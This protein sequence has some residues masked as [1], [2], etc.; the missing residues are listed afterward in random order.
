MNKKLLIALLTLTCGTTCAL[1]LSACNGNKHTHSFSED[2]K[3]D[4]NSHWHQA[5]CEHTDVKGS[6]APHVDEDNNGECDI[7]KYTPMDVSVSGTYYFC[8]NGSTDDQ[9]Y[10]TFKNGKWTDDEGLTGDYS[11][12]GNTVTLYL[13]VENEK[14][15]FASGTVDG[16]D[17]AL[18]LAGQV[19]YRKGEDVDPTKPKEKTLSYSLSDDRSYYIVKGIGGLTGDIE[20][21]DEYKRKPVKEIAENA[22]ANSTELTGLKIGSNVTTIGKKAFYNCANLTAA[23]IGDSVKAVPASAFENCRK[24]T[25]ITVG[26]AVSEFGEKAFYF[27][28]KLKDVYFNGTAS[29]WAQINFV[30]NPL[31]DKNIYIAGN[32]TATAE[33]QS[34]DLYV[35]GEILTDAE[36]TDAETISKSAFFGY[37]KLQSVTVGGSVG[38]IGETA[39]YGCSSLK[40]VSVTGD[41]KIIRKSAFRDCADLTS[42]TIGSSVK[43]IEET[44]FDSCEK[45]ETV[46]I[47]NGVTY[48]GYGAFMACGKLSS[49]TLGNSVVEICDSAFYSCNELT[50][51]TIPSSTIFIGKNAFTFTGLTSATF[52]STTGWIANKN[53]ALTGEQLSDTANAA[54]LLISSVLDKGY[55]E[56]EWEKPTLQYTLSGDK[57]Y[58]IVNNAGTACRSEIVIPETH[59][60]LPVRAISSYAFNGC[61]SL[62]SISLPGCIREIGDY[63]FDGCSSLE[64]IE[65]RGSLVSDY[66]EVFASSDGVLYNADF[67]EVICVPSAKT[68]LTLTAVTEIADEMFMYCSN[69]KKVTIGNGVTKIGEMA[70]SG[71]YNLA[72]ISI[73]DSVEYISDYAFNGCNKLRYNEQGGNL[74][75]GNETNPYLV[76]I[77]AAYTGNTVYKINAGT[78]IIY[79]SGFVDCENVKSIIIHDGVVQINGNSLA[80]QSLESITVGEGNLNYASQNGVLYNKEK[81]EFICMPYA[82]SG[83]IVIPD[84]ITKIG[85]L[86]YGN[87]ITSIS[88]PESLTEI[89]SQT[90]YY[91]EA[92][93][94][95]TVAAG[96]AN[97]VS[98]NGIL[99]NKEKTEF[100]CIPKMLEGDVVI[101]EGI[102]ELEWEAFERRHLTGVTIPDSV[103]KI[104]EAA[105]SNCP[106]LKTVSIGKGLLEIGEAVF[107]GCSSLEEITVDQSCPN[108]SSQTGIMYN[109]DKTEFVHVPAAIREVVIADGITVINQEFRDNENLTS[110]VFGSGLKE[111][112]GYAFEHCK[113]ITS[114]ILPEGVQSIGAEAFYGC[115]N[116][117]EVSIP[118][119]II[120]IDGAFHDCDK[121]R[122]T[123]QNGCLYLGNKNNPYLVLV[124]QKNRNMTS[125]TVN[126]NTKI[127]YDMA[128][129]VYESKMKSVTIPDGIVQIGERAFSGC[130]DITQFTIPDSVKSIGKDAFYA[131][132]KLKVITFKGTKAQ[133]EK[134][135]KAEKWD[136][137]LG[138]GSCTVH[139][140]DGDISLQT[141]Y[142][143]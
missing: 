113:N 78:K 88:L 134:I 142:E 133:W 8:E 6:S 97:Y 85:S 5:N 2:W 121:L 47:G 31:Y 58:Y 28:L 140:T 20:I 60:E 37:E 63:A 15:E 16:D 103:T 100:I 45:L 107:N 99:Y 76:L 80:C 27:C 92:L 135:E 96:N 108:Y 34:R 94:S 125:C 50:T 136:N 138:E 114:I 90:F 65:V 30:S 21:P 38:E 111:I 64:S 42:V 141:N 116:L 77:K 75:L 120:Y 10:I 110:I 98:Q 19:C 101:P 105:F 74:Y 130:R 93:K 43:R 57:T 79:G 67:T 119:S 122:Y 52:Q 106:Y 1:G 118:D 48:I 9:L 26:S 66:E 112:G 69:L 117:T 40:T 25:E 13:T 41:V 18:D 33:N 70:F 82:I 24:L 95:I 55:A 35:N 137:Y 54:K 123:E 115:V 61:K 84:G 131:C 143:I 32:N 81:T 71:C 128:F 4:S 22:F 3:S 49:L 127:I 44:A 91:S 59:N 68:E 62:I 17:I 36:I 83:D 124:E 7:C 86:P 73:P 104:G 53:E 129:E 56:A 87:K 126:A 29:D 46:N 51:V 39:F 139:C 132:I 14:T 109:K 72:E 102:T 23:E 89:S 12:S 11:I